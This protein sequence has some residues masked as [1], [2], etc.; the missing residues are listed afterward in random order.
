MRGSRL[1]VIVGAVLVIG[2]IIIGAIFVMRGQQTPV[3]PAVSVEGTVVPE[4]PQVQIV[5]AAQD[6]AR[7]IRITEAMT[8]GE[9]PAVTLKDW[10]EEEVPPGAITRLEDVI[11]RTTRVDAVRDLP[12]LG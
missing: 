6:L 4:V 5:V 2:A 12:I 7:G 9:A 11:G 8:R 10:P 1:L 3:E